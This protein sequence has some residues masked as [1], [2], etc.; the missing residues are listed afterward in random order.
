MRQVARIE[1]DGS[2]TVTHANEAL[3]EVCPALAEPP[4]PETSGESET[5]SSGGSSEAEGRGTPDV[6]TAE[7][8]PSTTG[9]VRVAARRRRS[10]A[11]SPETGWLVGQRLDE[12]LWGWFGRHTSR[13]VIDHFIADCRLARPSSMA[14]ILHME[15]PAS[16][17]AN[18]TNGGGL[19]GDAECGGLLEHALPSGGGKL[20][21]VLLQLCP[22][23]GDVDEDGGEKDLGTT[24][25]QSFATSHVLLVLTPSNH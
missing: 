8:V 10:P 23:R 11:S 25:A 14:A 13:A 1:G 16:P 21:E 4:S 15:Q 24:S 7:T 2:L 20:L 18:P 9:T 5:S 19:E 12:C 6:E 17:G 22:L 3:L